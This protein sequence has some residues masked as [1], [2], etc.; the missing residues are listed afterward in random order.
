M[1]KLL[2][3][4]LVL[5]SLGGCTIVA[6][7]G[8]TDRA[9]G[10]GANP[11]WECSSINPVS[12]QLPANPCFRARLLAQNVIE[13]QWRVINSEPKVYIYDDF[14]RNFEDI[15]FVEA[16]CQ[17]RPQNICS[18]TVTVS[19][20][21]F[22]RWLLQVTQPGGRKVYVP[23]SITITPPFPPV[24]V[25]GGGFV[26]ILAPTSRTISW[27]ADKRNADLDQPTNLAWIELKLPGE[28]F[29]HSKEPRSGAYASL[30]VPESIVSKPGHKVYQ[31][32]DCHHLK[33]SS[34]K[35][36]SE[37][38]VVTLYT[39]ADRFL[40][41]DPLYADAG[42]DLTISFTTNSGD[43]RRLTSATLI[44]HS[45]GQEFLETS[46]STISIPAEILTAGTHTVSLISCASR[47]ETCSPS[48]DLKIL[49]GSIV[50]WE[51]ER[52]YTEDFLPGVAHAAIGAGEVLDVTYDNTGGIWSIGEFSTSINH[53]TPDGLVESIT[54]PIARV[55]REKDLSTNPDNTFNWRSARERRLQSLSEALEPVQPFA[56]HVMG[57]E[58]PSVVTSLGERATLLGSKLWFTQGGSMYSSEKTNNH[59]RVISIDPSLPES[60]ATPYDD[61]L[62]VYNIPADDAHHLGNN[63]VIGLTAT[64]DRIWIGEAR[65]LYGLK[66]PSVISSFIDNPDSC[67]NLL[68]F[69]DP[70]ALAN[71]SLQYCRA[72]RT[73]EQDGCI[74][75]FLLDGRHAGVKVAH[76][77]TDPVDDTIW[78]VDVRGRY[79][80]NLNPDRKEAFKL[81][82][83]P[84]PHP[85]LSILG[86]FPWSLK[87]KDDAVYFSEYFS[88]QIL[89]FDKATETFHEIEV[90]ISAPDQNL[91]SIDIDS[92]SDRLWF[93]LSSSGKSPVD[94]ST[95][96]I[97]YIDLRSWRAHANNP[98]LNNAIYGVIYK[99]LDSITGPNARPDITSTFNGIAIDQ[100][101]GKIALATSRRNQITELTPISGF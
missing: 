101:S 76:L 96:T 25:S 86:G 64:A 53:V 4:I 41:P 29:W 62:C 43:V 57:G 69:A 7:V 10:P 13:L 21:G 52:D 94:N 38:R 92:R 32:R 28:A 42:K 19:E 48:V 56:L 93:T 5:F 98:T 17:T 23:A 27:L 8:G 15:G 26:D 46:A 71:Q 65:E 35:F 16:S 60:I 18:T 1:W 88:H 63:Q 2:P 99:W 51:L 74:E 97:G 90:P 70:Q 66:P 87:V 44:P 39:G 81:Y 45:R 79:L 40:S 75:K 59:S 54:V 11:S 83:L 22:Y 9:S 55:E 85:G 6:G 3:V 47:T 67:E 31:F 14:G 84:D 95:S 77:A 33:N 68:N 100:K 78:F 91:H 89:R 12:D 73:P 72:G 58:E 34:R 24:E 37:P 61:R 82:P 20:G 50:E 80:A 30:I 36:C 49:V